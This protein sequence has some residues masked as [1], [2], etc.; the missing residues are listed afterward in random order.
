M[1]WF[2]SPHKV[3]EFKKLFFRKWNLPSG[4]QIIVTPEANNKDRWME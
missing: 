1:R 2:G 3:I 4:I